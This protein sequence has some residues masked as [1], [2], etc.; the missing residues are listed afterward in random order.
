MTAKELLQS[1]VDN[2]GS[3]LE[4]C[5]NGV[6]EDQADLK[7]HEDSMSF[8]VTAAHLA[9]CC[10]AVLEHVE[11]REHQ[12][13]T[14]K[15]KS[16]AL[17]PLIEEWRELRAKAVAATVSDDDKL[18]KLATDYIVGHDYYHVGQLVTLRLSFDKAWNS[19][20]IYGS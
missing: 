13:G 12:W 10:V 7:L 14:F 11:G 5:F 17:A 15:P 19:Y 1:L 20:S 3:Q 6:T 4:Q 9:E 18:I 8:R 2:A 16:A